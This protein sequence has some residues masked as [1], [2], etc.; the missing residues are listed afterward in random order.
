M[1]LKTY[2]V[3]SQNSRMQ[4]EALKRA[5]MPQV[6]VQVSEPSR[7]C[8]LSVYVP[9]LTFLTPPHF[10]ARCTRRWTSWGASS[11]G[12]TGRCWT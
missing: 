6:R 8:M 10:T 9:L 5:R 7:A 1:H 11:G 2:V 4:Y 12:S 3:R